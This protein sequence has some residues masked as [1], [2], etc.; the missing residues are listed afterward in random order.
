M[1]EKTA[2]ICQ[3][4]GYDSPKWSGKC[5]EC[6]AW[7][8]MAE[9]RAPKVKKGSAGKTGAESAAAIPSPLSE[10]DAVKAPR[11]KTGI[12]ELDRAAGGGFVRSSLLLLAGEPGIGK[13]TLVLQALEKISQSYGKV[14]YATGEESA[15]QIKI[16]ADRLGVKGD[17]IIV[18]AENDLESILDALR[19]EAYVIA[20]IDSVQTL[21]D[22]S[23]DSSAG[24]IS[25]VRQCASRLHAY[26]K[27]TGTPI[28][29]I[30][31]VT[32]DGSIAGPRALEHIVDATLMF[33]GEKSLQ[34]RL[35]RSIKNR[36]GGSNEVGVFEMTGAGLEEV[37]N[38]SALFVSQRPLDANGSAV[39]VTMEGTRPFLVEVQ[40]LVSNCGL[41]TPRRTTLGVD[42]QKVAM[43]AAALEKRVGF[44]MNGFDMFVNV[45]GGMRITEPAAD[46]GICASLASSFIEKPAPNDCAIIGE[47]GLAGEVRGVSAADER[48]KEALRLGFKRIVVPRHNFEQTSSRSDKEL[49]SKLTPVASLTEMM[50]ALF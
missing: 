44:E 21:V 31:H 29:L 23:F 7:G 36:Y 46:L 20:A 50:D 33:E 40:S 39:V 19:R 26:A 34:Y 38:P 10:I 16:R 32:K 12:A 30:G 1:S 22:S 6:G 25:Q 49:L 28:L 37:S 11:I 13:S 17:N 48:V 9:E 18:Y 42:H 43:L 47:V 27:Q 4:C 5:P 8:S 41:A 35:L 24:S 3:Q 2:F 45:A 14:L 15:L